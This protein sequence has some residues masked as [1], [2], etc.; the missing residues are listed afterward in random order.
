MVLELLGD[1]EIE[2]IKTEMEISDADF[3]QIETIC[4]ASKQSDKS[5]TLELN[6]IG[7]KECGVT[8]PIDINLITSGEKPVV[9]QVWT[10]F[11]EIINRSK[12]PV[13]IVDGATV[14]SVPP[15]VW[16]STSQGGS[17]GAF[18][19][20]VKS[21]PTHE[22]M[23]IEPGQKYIVTWKIDTWRSHDKNRE[24]VGWN[25]VLSR[26]IVTVRD[27]LFYKPGAYAIN[28]VVHIWSSPPIAN[29]L[30]QV[31][32]FYESFTESRTQKIF[33][34]ASP[35]VL[36]I[37]SVIGGVIAFLLKLI[38]VLTRNTLKSTGGIR[39]L[40]FGVISAILLC[41]IGTIL[42]ARISASDFLIT[43]QVGDLWGAMATGF[44]IQWLG[45]NYF[46]SKLLPNTESKDDEKTLKPDEG[47]LGDENDQNCSDKG[48]GH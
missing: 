19:P 36:I 42:I 18:F 28:S 10:V 24:T 26:V 13:W 31:V 33:V 29:D 21:R 44:F 41:S 46:V 30:G 12:Q 3:V 20:T 37:G 23:R 35:W 45:L 5:S 34:E 6:E 48:F 25:A 9:G 43:V 7:P 14:L 17:V 22:I 1:E 38:L 4:N 15:E 40:A 11:G 2:N 27:F 8:L 16:G 32:N 47:S 39:Y